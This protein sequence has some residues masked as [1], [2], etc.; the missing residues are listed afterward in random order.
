MAE[1]QARVFVDHP[2]GK[3]H[4]DET[5]VNQSANESCVPLEENYLRVVS[6]VPALV[7]VEN[8]VILASLFCYRHKLK[9]NN[10]Y[11]YVASALVANV[12]T[13]VLGFYHF[14]NYYYGFETTSPNP[15]WAFRKGMTLALSLVL[16]GNIGLLI[17]GI[18]DSTYVVGR[19]S[20][21]QQARRQLDP[22]YR[23]RKAT[24][25][26]CVVWALPTLFG[27]LA[28]T[29][30]NCHSVCTCT[31]SYK[32]GAPLCREAKCSRLYT[33]MSKLYLLVV[34]ILWGLECL[35]LLALLCSSIRT[36]RHSDSEK[37]T[38]GHAERKYLSF[39]RTLTRHRASHQVVYFL[40]MLFIICTAPIMILFVLDFAI[41][42][43]HFSHI[44]VNC[45]TP[46]PLVYCCISPI[47]VS[48]K[49]A[50]V[51]DAFLMAMTFSWLK[52]AASRKNKTRKKSSCTVLSTSVPEKEFA[53]ATPI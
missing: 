44:V 48:H 28:M 1:I 15:W 18:E 8:L 12:V 50:G 14:I 39:K 51:R 6:V 41:P 40:F 5:F 4:V 2:H 9:H 20:S 36:V 3:T 33:P 35:G 32:S 11:R 29:D 38:K 23:R 27:L 43:I 26:I 21:R 13:A 22:N 16:C 34:V 24:A 25:L 19:M 17:Y 46:L 52:P 7:A 45:I 49:L 10:V 31:L 30:W 37:A 42:G 47:L 53:N